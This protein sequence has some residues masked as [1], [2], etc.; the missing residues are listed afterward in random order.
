MNHPLVRR[1][2]RATFF[3]L[4]LKSEPGYSDRVVENVGRV[5][6]SGGTRYHSFLLSRL[7]FR[8]LSILF[9][10][11]SPSLSANPIF[12]FLISRVTFFLYSYF[13]YTFSSFY[14]VFLSYR[15]FPLYSFFVFSATHF[16]LL[17]SSRILAP[18]SGWELGWI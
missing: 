2:F 1:K 14:R 10:S 16:S 9:S 15:I 4:S 17:S 8:H 7:A 12:L 18:R 13:A 5:S 6:Q 11:F 3:F